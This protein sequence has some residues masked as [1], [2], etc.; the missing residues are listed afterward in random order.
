MT[1]PAVRDLFESLAR[2]PAFAE[3]V[4]RI[5]RDETSHLSFSGLT[6]T[7][8]ALYLVLLQQ[9]V[10]RPLLVIVDGNKQAEALHEAV[11]SFHQL[12]STTL[13]T[14][15]PLLLP[16]LDVLPAQRLSPHSE[17]SEQRAVGLWRLAT[18]PVPITITPVASA[19]LKTESRDFYRQ[20]ALQLRTGEEIPLEDLLAHLESVGY[21]RREPVEMVG[22][23]SIRGGILDVFPA[24]AERPV[25]VEFFGDTIDSM[26][27]FDTESQRS[28]LQ[29]REAQLLPLLEYPKNRRLFV[30]L[31]DIAGTE[32]EEF[33]GWEYYVPMLRPRSG[34]LFDL[35]PNAIVV[36]DEPEMLQGASE[37]LWI[38]LEAPDT[39]PHRADPEASFFRWS[40]LDAQLKQ[41]TSVNL[42]ELELLSTDQQ[43]L[44][45]PTRPSV[46]FHNN[47][48]LAVNEARS[49]VERGGRVAFFAP[50][51][52]ELE[53]LADILQ[54]Y[55]VP[56]QLGLDTTDSTPQYLAER[57]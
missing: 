10:T 18:K 4:R 40:D 12:L 28:V 19:L 41:H 2:H 46:A 16:A 30:D 54:E 33:A 39:R 13:E 55:R 5:L 1:H 17:I 11:S 52:G 49:T 56:F 50:T 57:A 26:R 15:R 44:Q 31:A 37:R 25:R 14:Q 43:P 36:L 8:K 42:R 27:R 35:S 6:L 21:E 45:V 20:L 3:L 34:S 47:I 22:E 7:A 29:V 9:A 53:R 23:Y 48:Q 32:G 38:R 51:T 24:E